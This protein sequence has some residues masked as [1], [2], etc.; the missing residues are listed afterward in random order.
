MA[1][2]RAGMAAD[3]FGNPELPGLQ[4]SILFETALR[5]PQLASRATLRKKKMMSSAV[6]QRMKCPCGAGGSGFPKSPR[7]SRK[8]PRPSA[9]LQ[10]LV[11]LVL[12][13]PGFLGLIFADRV[14]E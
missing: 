1:A 10:F 3:N 13:G 2:E 5:I 9:F 12:L 7:P 11:F 14:Q 4:R 6:F 8:C